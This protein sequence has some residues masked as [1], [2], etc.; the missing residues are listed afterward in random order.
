MYKASRVRKIIIGVWRICIAL[1]LIVVTSPIFW[2]IDYNEL[3]LF[4]KRYGIDVTAVM[5]VFLG[6]WMSFNMHPIRGSM[7]AIFCIVMSIVQHP[8]GYFE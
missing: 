2:L 6:V 4:V 7:L 8:E 1:C 5:S 3:A